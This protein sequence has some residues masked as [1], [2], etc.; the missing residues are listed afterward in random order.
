M[1]Q[2]EVLYY[3]APASV[4]T[5]AL[6]LGNGRIGAM[7]FSGTTL[8]RIDLN[9][10]TLWSGRPRDPVRP[11]AYESYRRAQA[12]ALRG[13]YAK[14]DRELREHFT[15]CWSQAYLPF[16]SLELKW[17][18]R[19]RCRDYRRTLDLRTA[20]L[21]SSFRCG[22]AEVQKTAFV[23]YPRDVLVYRVTA[24]RAFSLSVGLRSPLRCETA[25]EN[26]VLILDGQC[27]CDADTSSPIYPCHSLIYADDP[28]EGGICFR[29]AVRVVTDG[30]VR[31][32]GSGLRVADA[33]E[34]TL[35]FACKTSFN[36]FDRDPVRDGRD[37]RQPCLETLERAASTP[38]DEL[39]REHIADHRAY[40]DRVSFSLAVPT[41]RGDIPTDERLRRFGKGEE[42]DALYTL[43]FNY[44]R[45]LM[46]ASSR[47]GTTATNLQGIWNRD[48]KPM[49]NCNY[50]VNINTEMNVWPV[51]M[52]GCPELLSP[53]IGLIRDLS[54]TG[55]RVAKAFYHAEG[56]VVHHNA[57]IWAHA[58]PVL[59]DPSWAF[60]QGASGWLCRSLFEYYEYTLDERFLRETAF[61]LMKKAALFYLDILIRN[62]DGQWMIC[63][64]TSPENIFKKDGERSAVSASTAMQNDIVRDLLTNCKKACEI[65]SVNDPF[66]ER[67]CAVLPELQ[68]LSIGADGTIL[69]WNEELTETE[70][71]HRHVSQLYG[72]HPAGLIT[73]EKTPA[74]FEACKRTLD[75]RGDDG[76][77]WSLAWKINFHARLRQGDRALELLKAQLRPIRETAVPSYRHGGT[78]PNLFD[79]HPPFQIDGNFGAVSGIGE[80][81]LQS[82]GETVWLLPALPERWREGSV[83]SLRARGNIAVDIDWKDGK[84]THYALHGAENKNIRVVLCH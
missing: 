11:G 79:A 3:T 71:H 74:L 54:V 76:T 72:L 57:D 68:P 42:D 41:D 17:D 10:D 13:E 32:D 43:L 77:G 80:M 49:W 12:A 66:Y 48:K 78:Y 15:A 45:Y 52:C 58:A 36:G 51:L 24:E 83:R 75:K 46:I 2:D 69:E 9:Q 23:S 5:E 29:G 7:C 63:P 73:E 20:V 39:L 19:E 18:G 26:G 35:F 4:W 64:A 44:G 53:L 34:I 55:E 70:V 33:T 28:N 61:P 30:S 22:D 6:P 8:D 67:V 37:Y 81:L 21:R 27:P 38:F 60:W 31:A 1:L 62:R 65:L 14:A 82:D 40:Y 25:V 16:G 59:G 47:E 50:T 56:F 84:I